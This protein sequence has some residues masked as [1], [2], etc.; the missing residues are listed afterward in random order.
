MFTLKDLGPGE[1]GRVCSCSGDG[2]VFQRLCEMGF[3]EGA[4]LRVV[5]YAPLGDPME[6][7]IDNYHLSLRKAEAA[8]VEVTRV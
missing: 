3:V 8:M 1:T 7:E 6:V 2:G 4:S 5:R